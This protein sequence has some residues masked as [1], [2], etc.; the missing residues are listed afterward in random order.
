L[1]AGDNAPGYYTTGLEHLL[2]PST[3]WMS[4]TSRIGS[5]SPRFLPFFF[6]RV[7]L[8]LSAIRPF[9][10]LLAYECPKTVA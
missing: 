10:S 8:I 9:P 5:S 4:P 7:G 2:I 3:Q 1:R 6:V